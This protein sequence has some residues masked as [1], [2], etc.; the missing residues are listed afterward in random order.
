MTPLPAV[1]CTPVLALA[2]LLGAVAVPVAAQG[3]DGLPADLPHCVGGPP[4]RLTDVPSMP[5]QAA[6]AE[7]LW[8]E[9][10]DRYPV[11]RQ[12]GGMPA[13]MLMWRAQAGDWRFA[14]LG[15]DEAGR[16]CFSATFAAQPFERQTSRLL[17]KYFG[18]EV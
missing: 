7:A 6:D 14:A 15:R 4:L 17:R 16:T 9:A 10:L 12:E 13:G 18:R 11:L 2:V 3:A 8:R 5:L 1:R